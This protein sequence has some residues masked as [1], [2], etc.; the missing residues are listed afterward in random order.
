VITG[1]KCEEGDVILGL[2]SSGIH[3]N[4]LT[5]ARKVLGSSM[6]S[7]NDIMGGLTKKIGLE[8]LTPT[9]IYVKQVLEITGNHD[10]HGMVNIT[11]GGLRNICR[12]KKDLRYVI[13]D[14]IEPAPIFRVIQTLGDIEE[15][16][17]YQ[18]FNMSMG[19]TMIMPASDAEDVV[20]RY[21]NASIVGRVEKG[22]GVLLEPNN[23]L[24]EKY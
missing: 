2:M 5:L 10:V 13:D 23:I 24:Y 1:E 15:R 14:P 8:L 7:L 11:G 18:T 6:V 16:E 4:G 19:F 21:K 17:M 20:K 22:N 3:S 9:E 12:M